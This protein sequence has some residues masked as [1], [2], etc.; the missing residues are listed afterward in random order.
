MVLTV[1]VYPIPVS[2]LIY[3]S[4]IR[5][6][7]LGYLK[8][9]VFYFRNNRIKESFEAKISGTSKFQSSKEIYI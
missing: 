7:L 5:V 6:V 2:L 9:G 1:F 8:V 4:N 3:I